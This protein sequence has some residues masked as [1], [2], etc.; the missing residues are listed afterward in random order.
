MTA[1]AVDLR[2]A[3][4][5]GDAA[6]G[7]V[8][9]WVRLEDAVVA[10]GIGRAPAET[11][12]ELTMRVLRARAVDADALACLAALY[13]EARFS[14]H[15]LGEPDRQRAVDVLDEVLAQLAS[16]AAPA[17]RAHA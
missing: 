11:S 15:D 4:A 9:C 12:S 6:N 5:E 7:I 14:R 2:V 16:S 10:S 13:R 17:E 1:A 8:A 3:L